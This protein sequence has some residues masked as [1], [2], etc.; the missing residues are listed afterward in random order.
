MKMLLLWSMVSL[1]FPSMVWGEKSDPVATQVPTTNP[2]PVPDAGQDG[3]DVEQNTAQVMQAFISQTVEKSDIVAIED[4]TKRLIMF[5]M[6]V[7]LLLLL[8]ATIA[9]GVAMGVYGKQVF[10]A[11]MVCAGLSLTLALGHAVV[12]IVWFYPF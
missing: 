7:P 3:D 11:H 4:Q 1:F 10:V 5:S 9:L 8:I 2:A 12:G 6:G